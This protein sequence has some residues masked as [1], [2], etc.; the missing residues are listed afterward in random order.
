VWYPNDYS[1]HC[2]SDKETFRM[3]PTYE[4]VG[5]ASGSFENDLEREGDIAEETRKRENLGVLRAV[6]L[7]VQLSAD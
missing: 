6:S 2:Q 7:R 3:F 4:T 5:T 1:S